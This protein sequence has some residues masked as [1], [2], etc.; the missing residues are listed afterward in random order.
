M[1]ELVCHGMVRP[2]HLDIK[3]VEQGGV[4]ISDIQDS[5]REFWQL[6]RHT[7]AVK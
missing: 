6:P 4:N 3:G 7:R 2:Q 5:C 1:F